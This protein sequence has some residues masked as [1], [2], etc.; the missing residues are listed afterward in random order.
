MWDSPSPN[1]ALMSRL[2][3]YWLETALREV[4][5][6]RSRPRTSN[7]AQPVPR[8]SVT[9][10]PR[11]LRERANSALGR[12]WIC[13][14][15]VRTARLSRNK[16]QL[17]SA[18]FI[19]VPEFP[20]SISPFGARISPPTPVIRHSFGCSLTT[21]PRARYASSAERVSA[22]SS[23][24]RTWLTP[25]A[26]AAIA[27]ARIVCDFEPGISAAPLSVDGSHRNCM[28]CGMLLGRRTG[29]EMRDTHWREGKQR[30]RPPTAH[31]YTPRRRVGYS[32]AAFPAGFCDRHRN[33]YRYRPIQAGT[34]Y[35]QHP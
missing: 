3:R 31:E 19:V 14:S 28:G 29:P 10:A 5:P 7:G 23:G 13:L 18:T 25:V 21:A 22:D 16:A 24:W 30:R 32:A 17:P 15:P 33:R 8:R 34:P 27:T 9:R 20:T 6:P 4:S 35:D 12:R 11:S 1:G 26:S 2:V